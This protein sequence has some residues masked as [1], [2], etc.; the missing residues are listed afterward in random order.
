MKTLLFVSRIFAGLVFVF[1]GFVKAVDPSGS[2]IKFEEYF[3]SFHLDFLVFAALPLAVIL[4]AAE[5]MIGLN[6]LAGLRM[7]ITAFLLLIFMS[8]FTVLTFILALTNPV[9]DCGCF[10][11]AL[12]LTNWQTFWKNIILLVPTLFI[13]IHRERYSRFAAPSL[14]WG[15]TGINFL[16]A[17]LV[18]AWCLRHQPLLDFRPYTVGAS[19]P[20]KMSVPE[21][22]PADVYHTI[23]VYER[24]GVRQEFTES[25]FPWQDSTWKWV[26]T[27]QTLL[28]KGYEPPIHDF[29]ITDE[30]GL[31]LTERILQ[32]SSYTFLIVAPFLEKAS[33][34]GLQRMND[35]A[36]RASDLGF[37]VYCLTSSPTHQIGEFKETFQPAFQVC[38][39]D[40][41]TLKTII[42][43]N[44]GLLVLREGIILGKWNHADIPDPK[45]IRSDFMSY[46][47]ERHRRSGERT[48]LVIL[49]LSV[50][51]FYCMVTCFKSLRSP[52]QQ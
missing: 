50:L 5:L 38:T 47:M 15:L 19:I 9:S 16:L 31:E 44:P 21:G 4:S 49:A 32:D 40:E 17:V 13:F 23:L 22:A 11:D 52:H 3:L 8:F 39:T 37:P 25:N 27:R 12:I 48:A 42:R 26:E 34:K 30:E 45:D 7:R 20:E 14:E 35:L 24:N 41:T 46:L 1:S 28:K 10:G 36:L 29:S 43:A 51:V 2:A 33:G 18:S 6:L